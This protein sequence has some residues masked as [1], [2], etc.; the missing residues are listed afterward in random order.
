MGWTLIIHGGIT[1]MF[2]KKKDFSL[3]SG[4]ANRPEEEKNYLMESGYLHSIGKLFSITFWLFLITFIIGLFTTPHAFGI[5]LGVFMITLFAGLIWIQRYEVPHKRK[6][7]TWIMS[8]ISASSIIIIAVVAGTAFIGNDV[9]V[10][11][12][13][14]E[15]TGPYG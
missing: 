9:Y 11:E 2:A 14:F 4:F 10:E 8:I 12:S 6:K 5:G 15:I 3:L 13:T 7:M 1:Y